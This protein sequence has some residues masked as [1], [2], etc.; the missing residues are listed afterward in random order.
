M[1]ASSLYVGRIRHRRLDEPVREFSYPIWHALIDLDELPALERD[2]ALLLAQPV[3]PDRFRRSR[4]HGIGGAR[5]FATS[6][7]PGCGS[8]GV[9]TEIGRVQLLTH[10]RILGHVFNPVSF[11]FIQGPRGSAAPCGRRGQQHLRRDLLLPP[12]RRGLVDPPRGGQAVPRLAVP[13]ARRPVPISHHRTGRD[14]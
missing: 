10:L 2:A 6:S 13:A 3:Q 8:R 11:Y 7:R 14:V 12:R 9:E 5:R 1:A 4:S